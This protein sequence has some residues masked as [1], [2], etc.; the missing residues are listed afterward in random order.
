MI[1]RKP[2]KR[3]TFLRP[4]YLISLLNCLGK[5][6][7]KRGQR[8]LA[9]LIADTIPKQQLGGRKN[10]SIVDTPANR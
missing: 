2:N 1:L 4:Y 7:E 10:L 6:L 3:D 9:L 5:V 8:R